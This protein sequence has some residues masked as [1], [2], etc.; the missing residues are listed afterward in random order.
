MKNINDNFLILQTLFIVNYR[1]NYC[2][3]IIEGYK[4]NLPWNNVLFCHYVIVF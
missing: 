2:L 3:K 1:I 4:L